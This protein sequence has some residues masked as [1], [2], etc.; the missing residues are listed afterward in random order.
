[1]QT[2]D[3]RCKYLLLTKKFVKS[4]VYCTTLTIEREPSVLHFFW[5]LKTLDTHINLRHLQGEMYPYY[6]PYYKFGRSNIDNI[7]FFLLWWR[8]VISAA[9]ID[10][11]KI[12]TLT[13]RGR[14]PWWFEAEFLIF[15]LIRFLRHKHS[16]DF[17]R[18]F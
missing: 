15:S 18:M 17:N 11:R 7:R 5:W 16:L 9:L 12:D 14:R 3:I 10:W 8:L 13:R 6:N 2:L 1:M 4:V